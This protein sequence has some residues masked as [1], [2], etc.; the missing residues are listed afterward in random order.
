MTRK[1]SQCAVIACAREAR[2]AHEGMGRPKTTS[3]VVGTS[4]ISPQIATALPAATLRTSALHNMTNAVHQRLNQERRATARISGGSD[5]AL[6][7]AKCRKKS[8][9][10]CD[11]RPPVLQA[12]TT[13]RVDR[14]RPSTRGICAPWCGVA[15]SSAAP[16]RV[17]RCLRGAPLTG[18]TTVIQ[19]ASWQEVEVHDPDVGGH[20]R[21]SLSADA[22]GTTLQGKPPTSE[23]P[24]CRKRCSMVATEI[25]WLAAPAEG[26][27]EGERAP[28]AAQE[29]DA[30]TLRVQTRRR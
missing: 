3:E 15:W 2:S 25:K 6:A 27:R 19:L 14:T 26:G 21:S 29:K 23:H 8:W 22:R 7:R 12:R 17:A 10:S 24:W 13:K 18:L 1:E 16:S 30:K 20:P 5:L 4:P 9:A 28:E 11:H